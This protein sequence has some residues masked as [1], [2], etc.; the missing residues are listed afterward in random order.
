MA[1]TGE[2]EMARR[3]HEDLLVP[4]LTSHETVQSKPVKEQASTMDTKVNE[5]STSEVANTSEVCESFRNLPQHLKRC[6]VYTWVLFVD[7]EFE[8]DT[9]IQL[10]IAADIVKVEGQE[11]LLVETG[12]FYFKELKDRSIFQPYIVC[13]SFES[14]YRFHEDVYELVEQCCENEYANEYAVMKEDESNKKIPPLTLH[15]VF[16]IGD[17]IGDFD[18]KI[19][20]SRIEEAKSLLTLKLQNECGTPIIKYISHNLFEKLTDLRVLDL[21]FTGIKELPTSVCKLRNL[22]YLDVSRTRIKKLPESVSE[23]CDLETLKLR[24]C[25]DLVGLPNEMNKLSNLQYLDLDGV[26]QLTSM[27]PSMRELTNVHTLST[28]VVGK[29]EGCQIQELKYMKK[30]RGSLCI[31]NMENVTEDQAKKARFSDEVQIRKLE[32]QWSLSESEGDMEFNFI[33]PNSSIEQLKITRYGA[34]SFPHCYWERFRSLAFIHLRYCN[35]AELPSLGRIP[36]L[37]SLYIHEMHSLRK[38]ENDK[39]SGFMK[40]EVLEINGMPCLEVWTEIKSYTMPLLRELTIIDCP[41]LVT[42]PEFK[43]LTSLE[44]LRII[45]CLTIQFFPGENL[46]NSL[47]SLTITECATLEEQYRKKEGEWIIAKIPEIWIGYQLISGTET[48]QQSTG[49]SQIQ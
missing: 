14:T 24:D 15:S 37:K 39:L 45:L 36:N 31:R 40:L 38:M 4:V 10:W 27:P 17:K 29:E 26:H 1:Q 23:L 21:S 7:H 47:K 5:G 42:L 48:S 19:F 2:S 33:E 46:P 9:L 6:V 8:E 20:E 49:K 3:P 30:L 35:C 13:E 43:N 16:L 44:N 32:F 11:K 12:R 25:L 18:T 22:R 34:E 41:K 28:F